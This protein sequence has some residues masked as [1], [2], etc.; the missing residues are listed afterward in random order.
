MYPSFTYV[1]LFLTLRRPL[2]G[3]DV[4]GCAIC[5]GALGIFLFSWSPSA[6]I[7]LSESICTRFFATTIGLNSSSSSENYF[8]EAVE[9]LM[10]R[11][12]FLGT[13]SSSSSTSDLTAAI[14]V[15]FSALF[16]CTSSSSICATLM[17]VVGYLVLDWT[18][19]GSTLIV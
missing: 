8:L 9:F 18:T 6:I 13:I 4:T 10:R 7:S 2:A 15:L 16:I 11:P 5:Y 3:P 1:R 12:F 19:G 14:V 17:G